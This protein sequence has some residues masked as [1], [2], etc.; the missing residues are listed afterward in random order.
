M[1]S[2]NDATLWVDLMF[3][4]NLEN[5]YKTGNYIKL[6]Y[7]LKYF[8]IIIP[9]LFTSL[10]RESN[11]QNFVTPEILTDL[12]E[13][14]NET[15]GLANLNGEIWT[16]NDKGDDA[17]L[18]QV[19]TVNGNITR[20]VEIMNATNEDWEDITHDENYIYVGDI[21]NNY[22]DRTDLKIFKV[23]RAALEVSDEVYAEI[24]HYSYSDQTSWEPNHNNNDFDC[25]ALISYENNLYLFSKNWVD[26][27]TRCYELSKQAGTHVAEYQSTFD[28]EYL[29]TGAEIL[30]ASN[31][32]VLIGYN[33]S[34][35]SY[36]WIFE[37]FNGNDFF[38]GTN[39]KLIWTSLTQIEGV[40]VANNN[41]VYV[42]TE[43]YS[44]FLDPTLYYHDIPDSATVIAE[45]N[46]QDFRIYTSSRILFV[47]PE[48]D[49]TITAEVQ[50]LST[51]GTLIYTKQCANE[52]QVQIPISFPKGIYIL[53]V[54]TKNGV[55]SYKIAL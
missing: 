6:H 31:S 19:N 29:V 44:S 18:Y 47:E 26:H 5:F 3:Y 46:L 15:S 38:N 22:G 8:A 12:S 45:Q 52:L 28:I 25:E 53:A 50:L 11:A 23:S 43:K 4:I 27:Q 13:M 42:S 10:L 35:G 54:S 9:L 51:S 24:I 2:I 34:G 33:T 49:E 40:C 37:D 1:Q 39:T 14:V 16:H 17:I 32:L 55:S 48:F 21:G 41:G 7:N 20:I 36:T 30:Q